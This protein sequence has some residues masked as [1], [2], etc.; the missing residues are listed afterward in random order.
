VARL[1]GAEVEGLDAV[2]PEVEGLI[3]VEPVV[4]GNGSCSSPKAPA[5]VAR[6]SL[7]NANAAA[8]ISD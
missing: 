3:N 8:G 2:V 5:A 7:T 4:G 6:S 1:A